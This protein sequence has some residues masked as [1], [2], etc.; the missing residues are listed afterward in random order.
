MNNSKLNLVTMLAVASLLLTACGQESEPAS[1]DDTVVHDAE[2]ASARAALELAEKA[3]EAA[4]QL[5]EL[6]AKLEANPNDHQARLDLADAQAAM[7]QSEEAIDN[8]LH[9]I[10]VD[11][12][13]NDDAARLHLLKVFEALGPTDEAVVSGRRRLSSLLFS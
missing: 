12:G 6:E 1:S 5:G 4:S 11:R 8:L 13:W 2:V 7:G 9:I 10:M 3:G